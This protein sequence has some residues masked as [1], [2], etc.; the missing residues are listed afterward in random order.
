MASREPG[1]PA[2]YSRVVADKGLPI[3]DGTASVRSDPTAL[4][5]LSRGNSHEGSLFCV[6]SLFGRCCGDSGVA[7]HN[8]QESHHTTSGEGLL[9]QAMVPDLD[10]KAADIF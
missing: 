8:S 2:Q 3:V 6:G 9:Q 4:L 7:S 5:S 10:G 1:G